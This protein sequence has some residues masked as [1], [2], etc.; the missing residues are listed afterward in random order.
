MTYA[1]LYGRV[2]GDIPA[3]HTFNASPGSTVDLFIGSQTLLAT[4]PHLSMMRNDA[5]GTRQSECSDHCPVTLA[6]PIPAAG[7]GTSLLQDRAYV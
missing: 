4:S 3:G 1:F 2:D 6:I 7:Q 5:W